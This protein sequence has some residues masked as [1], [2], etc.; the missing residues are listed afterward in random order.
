[1]WEC[2][3][4]EIRLELLAERVCK[5]FIWKSFS[6]LWPQLRR[7]LIRLD[8][9]MHVLC[10]NINTLKT[11]NRNCLYERKLMDDTSITHIYLRTKFQ[12]KWRLYSAVLICLQ[13]KMH[14]IQ[15]CTVILISLSSVETTCTCISRMYVFKTWSL[16]KKNKCKNKKCTTMN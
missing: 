4:A 9:K 6:E 5:L 1:M 7:F 14:S 11:N 12:L 2:Y 13:L 16:S 10:F 3:A 15:C 8:I